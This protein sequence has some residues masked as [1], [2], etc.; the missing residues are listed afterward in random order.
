M[1]INEITINQLILCLIAWMKMLLIFLVGFCL[2]ALAVAVTLI[3]I[4]RILKKIGIDLK[5]MV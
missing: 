1:T 3:I 4:Y 5:D 2:T